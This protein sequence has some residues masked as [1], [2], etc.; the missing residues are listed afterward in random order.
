MVLLSLTIIVQGD[1][2]LQHHLGIGLVRRQQHAVEVLCCWLI[3]WQFIHQ[4]NMRL[5]NSLHH[6]FVILGRK[7]SQSGYHIGNI[8]KAKLIVLLLA[9]F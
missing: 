3:L 9:F 6:L 2:V 5:I 1:L 4:F 8:S 7:I